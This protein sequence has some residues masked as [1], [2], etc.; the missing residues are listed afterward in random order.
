MLTRIADI[1]LYMGLT[2]EVADCYAAK[3]FLESV[4]VKYTPYMYTDP[5]QHA[6]NFEAISSWK[7]E[8]APEVLDKF[9]FVIYTEIHDDLEPSQYPRKCIYGL[10][11]IKS[12]G[13]AELYKT[14]R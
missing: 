4:Q 2:P 3:T 1:Q 6:A 10:D 12:S 11:A 13:I 7:L 5:A 8:G 9:P 14:G